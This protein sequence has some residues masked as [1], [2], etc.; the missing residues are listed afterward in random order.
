[1][2][3][4]LLRI[5]TPFRANATLIDNICLTDYKNLLSRHK[6]DR[7]FLASYLSLRKNTVFQG[8]KVYFDTLDMYRIVTLHIN[9]IDVDVSALSE[10]FF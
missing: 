3:P 4:D 1:M 7:K 5:A 2:H 9:V 10:C 8:L 6:K